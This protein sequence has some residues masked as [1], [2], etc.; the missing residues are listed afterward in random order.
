MISY[1]VG[2]NDD[3]DFEVT[4]GSGD[5]VVPSADDEYRL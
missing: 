3:G 4:D 1:Y 2:K 5:L